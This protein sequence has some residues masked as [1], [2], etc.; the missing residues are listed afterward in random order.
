MP[1][2]LPLPLREQIVQRCQQGLTHAQ[3]AAELKI[4]ARSVRQIWTRYRHGGAAGLP[5]DYARCGHPGSRF[6]AVLWDAAL[7]AKRE[8]PRWG[9]GFIRVQL[10][11]QFPD[12]PLPGVRTLQEWFRQAGLQPVRAQRPPVERD[13]A[14]AVHEVWEMDAK[15]R[16]RLLDGSGASTLALTDEASGALL[17]TVVFPPVSLDPGGGD[18]GPGGA[19]GGV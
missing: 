10:A 6:P 4:K 11:D 9:A 3:V 18:E 13:R 14:Q 16:M 12:Q 8:H 5:P 17:A 7:A 19:A 1:Q 15:E 2:A